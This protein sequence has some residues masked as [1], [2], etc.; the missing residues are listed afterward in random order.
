M[1]IL[2]YRTQLLTTLVRNS[3]GGAAVRAMIS[4]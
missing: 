4:A 2:I 1:R 3:S